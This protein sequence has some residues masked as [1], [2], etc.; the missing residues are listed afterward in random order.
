MKATA[1]GIN[2]ADCAAVYGD[3]ITDNILCIDTTGGHGTCNV[4]SNFPAQIKFEN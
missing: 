3:I 4:N 2:T 1:P